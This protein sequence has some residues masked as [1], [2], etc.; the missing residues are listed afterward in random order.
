LIKL[1]AWPLTGHQLHSSCVC[2]WPVLLAPCNTTLMT[3]LRRFCN[4]KKQ[5][6]KQQNKQTEKTLG[7]NL[8]C[9]ENV[10]NAEDFD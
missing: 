3:E 2:V 7:L 6:K 10:E 5:N 8:S 1:S 9:V 4:K